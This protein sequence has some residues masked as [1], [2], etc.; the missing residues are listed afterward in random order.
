MH[1]LRLSLL[2]SSAQ[3]SLS[4][5]PSQVP[6]DGCPT[7]PE[8]FGLVWFRFVFS[9]TAE[10]NT[11]WMWNQ[12]SGPCISSGFL[13]KLFQKEFPWAS[14]TSRNA[15]Y[16]FQS[17][18][19]PDYFSHKWEVYFLITHMM[20]GSQNCVVSF[21][22]QLV[23]ELSSGDPEREQ[24]CLD[25]L[26]GWQRAY[27]LPFLYFS[28]TSCPHVMSQYSLAER[29]LSKSLYSNSHPELIFPRVLPA[30]MKCFMLNHGQKEQIFWDVW[31]A[32]LSGAIM[33]EKIES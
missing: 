29:S 16:S 28:P 11:E 17:F 32:S 9:S 3:D 31:P 18:L 7:L 15:D 22:V 19:S 13:T 12:S 6:R 14:R 1:I 20:S 33:T 4:P 24:N 27:S 26:P 23:P 2:P 25:A 10:I 21:G 30:E 5:V 8:L